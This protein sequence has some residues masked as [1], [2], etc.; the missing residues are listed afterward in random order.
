[1]LMEGGNRRRHRTRRGVVFRGTQ[2]RPQRSLITIGAGLLVMAAL[3][4]ACAS[5]AVSGSLT[6]TTVGLPTGQ[7]PSIV[8]SGPGFR[9]HVTSRHIA[10]RGLRPGRYL[11]TVRTVVVRRGVAH[12]HAGARAYPAK[13]RVSVQVKSARTARETVLYAAVV[14]PRVRTLPARVLGILGEARDPS[15]ILLSAGVPPPAVGT[16]FT[17]GPTATLPLG[18]ISKVTGTRRKGAQLVVLLVAVPVTEAVPE[19]SF[20]GSLPLSSTPGAASESG[21]VVPAEAATVRAY[22]SS[23]CTP[24]K[25]VKLGAHLDSVELREAFLGTWPPQV[26]LT[27]AVR[28]TESLGVA[29][30]AAG[31]NCDFDLHELGPYSAAIPVGPIVIPVYATVP[32]KAGVHI[33]GTL[34]AGTV[35]VASTTVARAAAGVDE[36]AASLKQQGS[37]V[38]LSGTLALTG[39]AKLSAS[40][41]VQAGIG[42]A[43]GANVHLEAGFGPEFDW[44]SG[45]DCELLLDLGSLSA[46]VSVLGK[47]L[48]TPSFTPL[49]LSLWHGC[50]PSS[51]PPTGKT[52]TGAGPPTLPV[53]PVKPLC[54]ASGCGSASIPLTGATALDDSWY[55][56]TCALLGSGGIDCWGDNGTGELG[57]GISTNLES[58]PTPVKVAGVSTARQLAN[59]EP[60][61]ALLISGHIDCWGVGDLGNGVITPAGTP[62]TAVPVSGITQSRSVAVGQQTACAV[63]AGGSVECWG[64][65]ETGGLGN[66]RNEPH[67]E[68]LTPVPVPGI[69][70]AVSVAGAYDF[71][72]AL[73]ANGHVECWGENEFGELGAGPAAGHE[74][75][76][77]T[78]ERYCS[79]TPLE[80]S[81]ITDATAVS[82]STTRGCALLQTRQVECWGQ[83]ANGV[84]GE[85]SPVPVSIEGLSGVT[86]ISVGTYANCALL[87]SGKVVCWGA[88]VW[89]EFGNGTFSASP[90][91]IPVT[92]IGP[93]TAIAAGFGQACAVVAAG[94]VDCWGGD[95]QGQLGNGIG[96]S[97]AHGFSATPVA[98][99]EASG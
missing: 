57:N 5:A 89:G 60:R 15:A 86:A 26:K 55:G 52:P 51:S 56:S 71:F 24:P 2:A 50:Q 1:M 66:G 20:K 82:V 43:K 87:E 96:G 27:L 7:H 90:T 37:N 9:R 81:G 62:T 92:G 65:N 39:S 17:S 93:A 6:I 40:I 14:N 64:S 97:T 29:V 32:L 72:C 63:I 44:S 11:L 69:T 45:H 68:A 95:A 22:A 77:A 28:T 85:E 54:E 67:E 79:T 34:Q 12:L 73:L 99:A 33:N 21:S 76:A 13:R 84:Y 3:S 59:G 70:N 4:P 46:G 18:L 8:A 53:T 35:N 36:T 47:S 80:V 23:S 74:L 78:L 75:C 98:V 88:G 42:I 58:N 91:P 61:C 30:A 31:V 49:K 41:G 10:L 94:G 19:L 83:E 38:W 48:N 25:I 16:I